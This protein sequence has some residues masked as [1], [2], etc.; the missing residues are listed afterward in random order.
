MVSVR[1]GERPALVLPVRVIGDCPTIGAITLLVMLLAM[2]P[3]QCYE[4]TVRLDVPSS[5]G[6]GFTITRHGRQWLVT[7]RHVVV[8]VD[9]S[10]ITVTWRGEPRAANLAP[11]PRVSAADVAVFALGSELTPDLTL[12]PTTDGA[13]YTQDVYFLGYPYGLGLQAGGVML[14]FVKKA[15]ISA[16]ME[17]ADGV[18]VWLLD[19]IN[20]PGF[21]GGPVVFKRG[22][23]IDWCVGCVV[24]GYQF[25]DTA[26]KGGVGMVPVNTGIIYAYDIRYAT[27]AI[28]AY[29]AS[30]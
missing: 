27:E 12:Y 4:R 24:S 30:S 6:T 16:S 23:T 21:S 8:D 15:I 2:V 25:E 14:P 10:D 17:T 13:V 22:N 28:D 20:N 1:C 3:A 19:G 18:Q 5:H 26:V 7:A 9:V 29:V 11:V